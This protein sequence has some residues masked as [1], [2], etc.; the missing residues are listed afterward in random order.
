MREFGQYVKLKIYRIMAQSLE[1]AASKGRANTGI[2]LGSALGG[3]ALLGQL[4][5][6]TGIF[7]GL[8]NGYGCNGRRNWGGCGNGVAAGEASALLVTGGPTTFQAWEKSCDDAV[9][10]TNAFWRARVTQLQESYAHRE[11]DVNEKHGLYVA[12]RDLYDTLNERYSQKFNDLDKQVA[13]LAATRPYQDALINCK[14]DRV[15]E[16]AD[17]NLYRRTCRMIEGRVV[18]PSTPTVTGFQSIS[19][20][21][22]QAAAATAPSA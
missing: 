12:I 18:L 1:S 22:P 16:Q 19:C 6:G 3:T 13:V 8:F 4:M 9:E 21:C 7:G 11:T 15:A 10:L 20:P 5:D 14:I 2:A 17:F